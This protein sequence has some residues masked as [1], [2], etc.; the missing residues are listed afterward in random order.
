[1]AH[2]WPAKHNQ[3][4][5]CS[6]PKPETNYTN[7]KYKQD[8]GDNHALLSYTSMEGSEHEKDYNN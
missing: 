8:P 1:M 2:H 3:L 4:M 6:K 5:C 7:I